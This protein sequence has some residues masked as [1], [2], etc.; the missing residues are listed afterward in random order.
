MACKLAP[1]MHAWLRFIKDMMVMYVYV[2]CAGL[3]V[4]LPVLVSDVCKLNIIGSSFTFCRSWNMT[5]NNFA[6]PLCQH[7]A[8]VIGEV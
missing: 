8:K 5:S 2:C 7:K 6:M 3:L 4:V 1:C